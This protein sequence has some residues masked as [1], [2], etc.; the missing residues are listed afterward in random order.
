M[1]GCKMTGTRVESDKQG[2]MGK[3]MRTGAQSGGG[4]VAS[5]RANIPV[6]GSENSSTAKVSSSEKV[7]RPTTGSK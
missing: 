2:P 3:N 1:P 7:T 4:P 6:K 5:P